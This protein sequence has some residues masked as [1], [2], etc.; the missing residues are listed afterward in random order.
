MGSDT[1]AAPWI[2]LVVVLL[3]SV[4]C[5]LKVSDEKPEI[6]DSETN[7]FEKLISDI[8]GDVQNSDVPPKLKRGRSLRIRNREKSD[9]LKD[10]KER[11]DETAAMSGSETTVKNRQPLTFQTKKTD[12]IK[13][14]KTIQRTEG[15]RPARLRSRTRPRLRVSTISALKVENSK[16]LSPIIKP[17]I[18]KSQDNLK[19]KLSSSPMSFRHRFNP[20]HETETKTEA[21]TTI[22]T[23][24]TNSISTTTEGTTSRKSFWLKN[25]HNANK[26]TKTTASSSTLISK[27]KNGETTSRRSFWLKNTK[28]IS[29]TT[30]TTTSSSI[31]SSLTASISTTTEET[32]SRKSFWL[33][34]MHKGNKVIKT[35]ASAITSVSSTTTERPTSRKSFWPKTIKNINKMSTTSPGITKIQVITEIKLL[36]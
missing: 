14:T 19:G 1:M 22:S 36:E 9:S 25:T 11:K 18:T 35:P 4:S 13:E 2:V 7:N 5:Q 30:Q 29:K 34:N 23:S 33:R 10:D 3:Q 12:P 24:S 15:S 20:K 31:S 6:S 21:S 26:P 32:A 16:T 17:N 27:N 8:H 28:K